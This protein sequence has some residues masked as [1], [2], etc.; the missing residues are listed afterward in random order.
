MALNI[1]GLKF[2]FFQTITLFLLFLAGVNID[3]KYYYFSFIAVAIF[4]VTKRKI[5]LDWNVLF[6]LIFCI[7]WMLFSP[8]SNHI[9]LTTFIKPFLY[10]AAYIV[11]RNYFARN[12]KEYI[13]EKR[14]S[15]IIPVLVVLASGPFTHYLLNYFNGMGSSS[16]NTVDIWSGTVLSATGQAALACIMIGV[17]VSTMFIKSKMTAKVFA[18]LAL[19]IVFLYNLILAGR[20]L[21][22]ILIIVTLV[23][24]IFYFKESNSISK[25]FK[26]FSSIL[27]II[28]LLYI[29][30]SY[31]LFGIKSHI[32]NSNIYFRFFND[33][34]QDILSGQRGNLKLSHLKN[35]GAG[36]WGGSHIRRL[37]GGYAH[38]LWLDAYDEAGIF[39]LISLVLFSIGCLYTLWKC[40]SLKYMSKSLR[41]MLLAVYTSIFLQFFVEPI[42]QGMPWLFVC[43]CFMHGVVVQRLYE[44]KRELSKQQL[45]GI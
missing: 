12:Q 28:L 1:K 36:L 38:D 5:V 31:N 37:C 19:T 8:D 10:P 25:R 9:G 3:N 17:A 41:L 15:L 35:F 16:R 29:A 4:I 20:T 33:N 34:S 11:G 7:S 39:A 18:A 24:S 43:F 42:I 30:Y 45:R 14:D 2:D 13:A 32:A 23:C 40:I 44:A 27:V 22:L 26:L 21:F 6:L